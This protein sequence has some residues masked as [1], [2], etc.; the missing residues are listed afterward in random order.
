MPHILLPLDLACLLDLIV[1]I[2]YLI[3]FSKLSINLLGST[4]NILDSS[5]LS[6][7]LE[8]LRL[9]VSPLAPLDERVLA[10]LNLF[11]I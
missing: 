8:P 3:H 5:L 9:I 1:S 4:D 2:H 10:L 7:Y 11:Y 6:G